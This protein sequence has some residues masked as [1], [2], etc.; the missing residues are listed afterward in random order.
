MLQ[1]LHL[2]CLS[3]PI[4]VCA[5]RACGPGEHE[6]ACG[7]YG[8]CDITSGACHCTHD[9]NGVFCEVDR[10]AGI[11]ILVCQHKYYFNITLQCVHIACCQ[12]VLTVHGVH[13]GHL[14]LHIA[15]TKNCV[16]WLH[17]HSAA[18]NG[19]PPGPGSCW[20]SGV[21]QALRS[22]SPQGRYTQMPR[23]TVHP[24]AS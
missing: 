8:S 3:S 17:I 9:F 6:A 18:K 11:S 2:L 1:K 7:M 16:F 10:A 20:S 21:W 5:G 23:G 19:V 4:V 22:W 15:A 14:S 12:A 13:A 24:P